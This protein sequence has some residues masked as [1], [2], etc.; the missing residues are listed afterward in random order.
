MMR[1]KSYLQ[2][3]AAECGLACMAMIADYHGHRTDL[4]SLRQRFQLSLKGAP[5]GRL[6]GIAQSLGFHARAVRLTLDELPQLAV[7]CILHWNLDH[8]VV[9]AKAGKANVTIHDPAFG[10]RKLDYQE[11]SRHFTGVALELEPGTE[12]KT[13]SAPPAIKISQLTGPVRGLWSSLGQIL[14]LSIALQVFVLLAPFFMQLVVDHALVS[15]DRDLLTVLALGFGLALLLQVAIGLLRGW[16]LVLL[17]TRLG[18][19]WASNV[20]AH[21][22][23][24]PLAFFEKRHLGDVVSRMGAVQPSR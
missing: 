12:F 13:Q 17:S 23:R 24:L 19:Q 3:Q 18:L 21:A 10:V 20:F 4:H 5:L 14:L 15:A 7:P 16:A 6:I 1:L 8:Y 9:L 11:V 22:M 2:A